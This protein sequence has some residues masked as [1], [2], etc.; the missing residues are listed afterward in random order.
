M[1][2][3]Q[4]FQAENLPQG[5]FLT[6]LGGRRCTAVPRPVPT[7]SAEPPAV[8]SVAAV[9]AAPPAA[10]TTSIG[11]LVAAGD[12]DANTVPAE[13]SP[14]GLLPAATTPAAS[15]IA[16]NDGPAAF[17]DQ[18][19]PSPSPSPD[20]AFPDVIAAP[21][22]GGAA[23][24][25]T[26]TSPTSNSAV[27][28]LPSSS[29]SSV[30]STVAVAGGVIGGVVA[31]SIAAFLIWW[32]RRRVIKKRRSTLL[33]PLDAATYRDDK[34]GQYEIN[35]GS[36]G[37]T[38]MGEK[39]R[40]ALGYNV[41]KIRG[42]LL[43]RSGPSV[44]MDRGTSQFIEVNNHS[45]ATS[46]AT[47]NDDPGVTTKERLADWWSRLRY[48]RN[49][50]NRLSQDTLSIGGG[51]LNNSSIRSEKPPPSRQP[52]FLTLLNMDS[53][54]DDRDAARRRASLSRPTTSSSSPSQQFLGKLD[55]S[56]DSDNP[57][58]DAHASAKPAP[59]VVSATNNPFSDANAIRDAAST[60]PSTYVA[61]MRRSRGQSVSQQQGYAPQQQQQQP[62][63]GSVDSSF[64]D[65][66]NKFRSDPFDLEPR[67]SFVSSTAGTAGS[68]EGGVRRPAGAHRRGDSFTS[69]YSSGISMGDWSDPGPDVG[70][71]ASREV[72][73]LSEEEEEEEE[74]KVEKG[75]GKGRG[76][77]G[78]VGKAM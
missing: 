35:R 9:P 63:R 29:G 16:A 5:A 72:L 54:G 57:F 59:L 13:A 27:S 14:L 44:N 51:N 74:E 10:A 60:K 2:A 47:I 70:P 77:G 36:I 42:R 41:K 75:K 39:F 30:Q 46:S 3:P 25:A 66:R 56:F 34:G 43:S 55:L 78:S 26:N 45:R 73:P 52:D 65:R 48:N 58:S 61:D 33:T 67:R 40:A 23:P 62:T 68:S 11:A 31:L 4:V 49:R 69:K 53:G 1:S 50:E 71:A 32:W 19:A 76:S 20:P 37:P 18:A 6:T 38:P 22:G 64:A 28:M 24:G 12:V 17:P 7:T 8:A 21:T 15:D